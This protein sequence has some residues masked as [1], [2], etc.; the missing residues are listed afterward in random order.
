MSQT[1]GLLSIVDSFE[2][3]LDIDGGIPQ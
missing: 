1:L 2:R 3:L